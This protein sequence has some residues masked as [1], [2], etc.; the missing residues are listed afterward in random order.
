MSETFAS[1]NQPAPLASELPL[2][3]PNWVVYDQAAFLARV[4]AQSAEVPA[5]LRSTLRSLWRTPATP[6]VEALIDATVADT[7]FRSE[8]V[9]NGGDALAASCVALL[10]ALAVLG[11]HAR[12][13]E[14]LAELKR[15]GEQLGASLARGE[16]CQPKLWRP[17]ERA[18]RLRLL[19][20]ETSPLSKE[21]R[22]QMRLAREGEA[23]RVKDERARQ[24]REIEEARVAQVAID[25]QAWLHAQGASAERFDS[26]TFDQ[27]QSGPLLRDFKDVHGVHPSPGALRKLF[28]LAP[29]VHEALASHQ[30]ELERHA[31]E[32]KLAHHQWEQTLV[33]YDEAVERLHILKAELDEWTALQRVPV[34][35]RKSGR[36]GGQE[37]LQVLFDP[38]VLQAITEEQ[39]AGWRTSDLETLPPEDRSARARSVAR[40]EARRRL[41]AAMAATQVA[42]QCEVRQQ[43]DGLLVFSKPATVPVVVTVAPGDVHAWAAVVVLQASLPAP[44]NPGEIG[45]LSARVGAF[46]AAEKLA[47]MGQAI[48]N[49]LTDLVAE[50]A[51]ALSAS[52]RKE[53]LAGLKSAVEKG[54]RQQDLGHD[55]KN[56]LVASVSQLLRR[57]EE[58]RAEE[59]VRLKDYPQAFPLARS[60]DRR[61]HFRLGPTNSGKTHDALEALKKASSGVYLAPLRLLAMEV[62]DRLVAHGIP[63]NLLT[64]EEHDLMEGARHTACTV[65]MMNPEREVEVAVVDEIQM[66]QDPGR[67]WAWTSALVGAPARDV[68]VCGADT[69]HQRCVEVLEAI[70]ERHETVFLERKTPLVVEDTPVGSRRGRKQAEAALQPGDAVIAFSRKDV[71][72]LSARYR[73]Q[74]LSVATIYGALAPE[75]RRTESE[76]F[77]SG[78]A[79]VVVATDAIGMGLNLPVR[80]VI[81]S[82]VHKYDGVETRPLN[83]SEVQQIAGRAGRFGMHDEG[84][85]T[86]LDREDLP[87]VRRML[88]EPQPRMR[89]A[90]TIAPSPWHVQSLS[91][92]L[93]TQQIAPIL[94]YFATRIAARSSLFQTAALEDQVGLARVV[95]RIAGKLSLDDKFTFSCAPIAHD[96]DNEL[97]YFETCLLAFVKG[98]TLPL[99]RLADWL[100]DRRP[101]FLEEAEFLSK[102]VSLYA[103][104]SYKFPQVYCDGE[105][106]PELRSHL[107]RYIERE[108]LRQNGFGKTSKE[109]FQSRQ[110]W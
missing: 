37:T 91:Q 1:N 75:V 20:A 108:L 21:E 2:A 96:K 6:E 102:D 12:P 10:H 110:R 69:V 70:G 58:E 4:V 77:A 19:Q 47:G 54:L 67:G 49:A 60:L 27:L 93:G 62:R 18:E 38:A 80:R 13:S 56:T 87:H 28:D 32:R 17:E 82:T 90:L 40:I 100:H 3:H 98:R 106:V 73:S 39:I 51:N 107:S 35:L 68:F 71:L 64:G 89:S 63:C 22:K 92:L 95:D 97:G 81:F 26:D 30:A 86:T 104:L 84:R 43:E 16:V 9:R 52:Q 7:G 103:W 11:E 15:A 76:R 78:E 41:A 44:K 29:A 45:N 105:A 5:K 66:L 85:V 36:K 83:A 57:I 34:A 74:G 42:H 50:Y 53:L 94:S 33:G 46:F 8:F 48:S 65:E 31:R 23:Q 14:L 101:G 25:L 99:P 61:I 59:L 55:L 24:S 88:A 109:A 79:D 72:T